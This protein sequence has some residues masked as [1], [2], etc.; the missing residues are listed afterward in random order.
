MPYTCPTTLYAAFQQMPDPRHRQG[1]RHPL[2]AVL[3]L[4]TA[5]M[6]SGCTS[7]DAIAQWGRMAFQRHR[8]WWRSLGF[9]SY[10]SPSCSTLSRRKSSP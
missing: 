10:R 7:L 1:R 6:I 2:S 5:A 4:A 3:T 9:R 8:T